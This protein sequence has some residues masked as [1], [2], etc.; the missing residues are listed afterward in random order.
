MA[1]WPNI[2]LA[3]YAEHVAFWS[4]FG[5]TRVISR[6]RERG[7]TRTSKAA[8]VSQQEETAPFSR[9]LLAVHMLAFAVM[10]FGVANAVLPRRVPAWF[11]GQRIVGSIIIAGGGVLVRSA[12]VY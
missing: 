10:Y 1:L 11:S 7:D 6:S 12:L 2:D 4:A 8:A 3:L 9:G 5:L